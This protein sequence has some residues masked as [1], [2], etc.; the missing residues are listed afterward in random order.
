M[1]ANERV[2]VIT[3]AASGI[4][5]ALT[6]ACIRRGI[7]VVMA[8]NAVS[9]LCDQVEQLSAA[10][11]TEVLGVVCD[12][13]RPES[14]R[15]LVK[16]TFERFNR[17]DLLFNNA[18][19]SGHFAPVWELT[20]EH[21]RK[22]MDVNLFG[23]IHGLQAFL[24]VLFKQDH[25]SHV[26]N[27]ASFYGLCSGS[28]MAAYAMSKHAIVALS[29]SLHFDLQRLEKPVSVSVVC[30]SFANTPLLSHSAPLHVDTLHT[31]LEEL[32]ARSRPAEDVAEH[33]LKE[34]EKGTFYILPDREVKEYCEQRTRAIIEQEPP[35]QHSLEKIISS[36]SRRAALREEK[37]N[38]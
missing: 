38:H 18:G 9:T 23:V 5:L 22:V 13:S 11:S 28:Q 29:E 2:A 35:H 4:G 17:V 6:Q 26:I 34:V 30:P 25:P 32:I 1:N 10:T 21:I 37:T 16:Q 31:M 24:P 20:S 27:M 3:G 15:H 19:I 12:V 14:L 7:H 8:D 36:L 33:I